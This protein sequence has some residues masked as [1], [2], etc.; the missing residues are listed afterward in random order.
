ML[1]MAIRV[2]LKFTQ[3]RDAKMYIQHAIVLNL[4]DTLDPKE[5]HIHIDGKQTRIPEGFANKMKRVLIIGKEKENVKII[6]WTDKHLVL[7][8]SSDPTHYTN[9][10]PTRKTNIHGDAVLKSKSVIDYNKVKKGMDLSDEMSYCHTAAVV[11]TF[12]GANTY[13]RRCGSRNKQKNTH[14]FLKLDEAGRKRQKVCKDCYNR[15]R[16]SGLSSREAVK[17]RIVT[18]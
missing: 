6:R 13:S 4:L 15:L 16:S 3:E 7:M 14:T 11:R 17:V 8:V 5:E 10:I 12:G 18:Q 1:Y 9:V 2:M